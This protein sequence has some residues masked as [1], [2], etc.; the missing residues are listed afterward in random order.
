MSRDLP[1]APDAICILRLS[2]IGDCCHTLPVVRTLQAAFPN[3]RISWVIGTIEHQLLKGADG[4]EFITFDKKAGL[5]AITAVRK[6]F[7]GSQFPVL[8]NMNA[9]MRA[10][11]VSAAI[12]ARRRIGFDRARARDF[13][14]AF[15][16]EKIAE[17][18]PARP[19]VLDGLFQFAEHL[20]ATERV[21][22]WDI[23]VTPADTEF[24]AEVTA[25]SG[26][27]CV[28]SPCSSQRARNFRNWSVENYV[29]LIRYLQDKHAAQVVLTGATSDIEKHYAT[30]IMAQTDAVTNLVGSTSLKQLFAVI[31]AADVV[32]CPD[33]GPAHMATAAGTPIVGLYA[34][35]NP[36][37]TGP[38]IDRDLT[39]NKYPEAVE[40]EFGKTVDQVRFGQR[41][42][43]PEAMAL[44][45][46]QDVIAKTDSALNRP[47]RAT[48]GDTED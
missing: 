27:T 8:L 33:S 17:R 43:D 48:A 29:E 41:V 21:M 19:H 28:I 18:D 16:N 13:Q 10:N 31:T 7:A 38:Y 35:S 30:E 1:S 15:S 12:P 3:T 32:I 37:R 36:V 47:S 11:L 14:W 45:K 46:L 5:K 40:I 42:R 39:V 6:H 2:A 22:R 23:P 9:S 26:P 25:G 44:I 24:A 20:G 4:I 34:T